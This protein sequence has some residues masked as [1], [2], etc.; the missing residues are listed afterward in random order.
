VTRP[1][2]PLRVAPGALLICVA[3]L[4]LLT[5]CALYNR[6]FH[7][8]PK[9]PATC[10]EKPFAGNAE[11]RPA[12]KV[13]EGLSAPDTRNAVKIP[14]LASADRERPKTEPCLALPPPFYAKAPPAA[15]KPVAPAPSGTTPV[16]PPATLPTAPAT[17]PTVPVTPPAAPATPQA[18]PAPAAPTVPAAPQGGSSGDVVP[19]G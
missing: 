11:S 4:P 14:E 16:T 2:S 12:L 9:N 15:A 6:M 18:T 19:P 5:G 8:S 7:R 3:L 17:P 1:R 13:P 10:H